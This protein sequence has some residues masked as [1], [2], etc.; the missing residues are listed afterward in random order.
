MQTTLAQKTQKRTHKNKRHTPPPAPA[1]GAL[2]A[3]GC[4]M[5]SLP[6]PARQLLFALTLLAACCGNTVTP[7]A[8]AAPPAV[9]PQHMVYVPTGTYTRFLK[10][11]DKKPTITIQGFY[12]DTYAVTNADCLAFVTANP[13]WRRSQTPSIFA[14]SHYLQHWKD[15][16]DL[17]SANP[18]SPVT[19][20][21]WFAAKAYAQWAGKRLPNFEEWEYAASARPQQAKNDDATTDIILSW[22]SRPAKGEPKPVGSTFENTFGLFDMHGLIWEWVYDF[23]SITTGGDSRSQGNLDQGLFCAAGSLRAE[24]KTDYAAFMRFAFRESLKATY[25]SKSLGFRCI[26]DLPPSQGDPP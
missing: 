5:K 15:D 20:V 19:Y 16:L 17:G 21:S 26:Q 12:M 11:D 10:S 24:D 9:A 2:S 7:S 18:N 1:G 6:S 3:V 25:T 14:D 8:A 22:Y 13:Q 23:N 4:T